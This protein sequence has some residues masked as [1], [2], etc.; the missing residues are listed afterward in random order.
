MHTMRF[1]LHLLLPTLLLAACGGGSPRDSANNY[2]LEAPEAGVYEEMERMDEADAPRPP[3]D[4]KIIR[5]G[6]LTYEV[7]DLDV[8]RAAIV[9]RVQQSGGYVEGDDRNDWG[10]SQN[11]TMRVRIPADGFDAFVDGLNTLGRLEHR[12]I[13]AVDVTAEWVDVEARL[14]AKRTLEQRYLEL[15]T[16]A[17]NVNE[18]LE[19]ERALA[20]VRGEIESMEARMKSLR[21]QVGMSSL[22]ITCSKQVPMVQRYTPRFGVAFKEGWNNL[23]RFSVWLA[24]LW[25]FVI[26]LGVLVWWWRKRRSRRKA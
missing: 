2:A 22:T 12:S 16:Q 19:V 25:P 26:L 10:S 14:A 1:L 18:M 24:N 5:S 17:R 3:A 6:S 11:L 15:A 7:D 20:E 8:A 23:L 9:Q 21:D 4:R 13:N